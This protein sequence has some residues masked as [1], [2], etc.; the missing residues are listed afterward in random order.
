MGLDVIGVGW[1]RTGTLSTKLALERLGLGPCHHM[2]EVFGSDPGHVRAWRAVARGEQVEFDRLYAG[3]RAAVDWPTVAFWRQLID[4]YPEAKVLLTRRDPDDWYESFEA[5]IR[6][7]I[8]PEHP[9]EDDD[10]AAMLH[11]VLVRH[12]FGGELGGREQLI[13]RYEEHV[14]EV[15][16]TVPDDRLLVWS[17]TEGW[18]RLCRFLG[19]DVPDEPFPRTNDREEFGEIFAGDRHGQDTET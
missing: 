18:P 4:A 5:T 11:E 2:L 9:G 17:V 3:Y 8:P 16:A 6:H 14:A 7:G 12:S 15:I 1:G 13:R 10:T 19:V